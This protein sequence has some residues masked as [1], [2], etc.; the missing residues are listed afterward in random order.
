[1]SIVNSGHPPVVYLPKKGEARFI[2]IKGDVMGIFRDVFFETQD[3]VVNEGDRFFL[4]SD[5][6]IERPGERKVWTFQ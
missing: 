2:E 3:I 6:L 4:Y 1:M 5:G